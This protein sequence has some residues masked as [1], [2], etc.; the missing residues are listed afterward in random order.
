MKKVAAFLTLLVFLLTIFGFSGRALAAGVYASGGGNKRVGDTFSVTISASGTTFDSFQGIISVSGNVSV[1]SISKG[2]ATFLPGKE[3]SNGGQFV[4]ITTE[5]SSLTI[6]TI[7]LKATKIGSATVSVSAVKL[8]YKGSIVGSDGGSTSFTIDRALNV[9]AAPA[10]A[11]SSHPDQSQSYTATDVVMSW[12]KA[13]GVTGYSYVFDQAADTTPPAKANTTDNTVTFASQAIGTYYF[14]IKAQNG[15]GWGS[16]TH[17]KISIKEPDAKV[18]ESLGKPSEITI[19]KTADFAND[20]KKGTVS[21]IS[22][23]GKTEPGYLA[24]IVLD[25]SPTLP[26][27]KLL[28][29]TA[30]E[31]GNFELL[32]DYPIRSGSYK[33]TVQGQLDKVLTPISDLIYF[34]ISQEKGGQIHVLTSN[35]TNVPVIPPLKWYEKINYRVVSIILGGLMIILIGLF[36]FLQIRSKRRLK[37]T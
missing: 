4:G 16:V 22:I 25:P 36:S 14:H 20:I 34:E 27:G 30:N 19:S 32:I 5:K 29:A 11:S 28:S 24:N 15:D 26:E 33:L 13:S 7:K 3:P 18:N 35:D 2:S 10:V 12:D 21:G 9:P 17:F 1:I 37:N 6:A 31:T 8:A 23:K